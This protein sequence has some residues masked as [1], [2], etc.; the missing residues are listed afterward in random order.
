MKKT[1]RSQLEDEYN[2][3][4]NLL[5]GVK[6]QA[7]FQGEQ[8]LAEIADQLEELDSGKHFSMQPGDTLGRIVAVDISKSH[9]KYSGE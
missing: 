3:L 4:L 2:Y 7:R 6:G 8:R 5:E 1:Q 9:K